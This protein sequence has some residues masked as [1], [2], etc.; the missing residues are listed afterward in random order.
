MMN[1]L[2]KIIIIVIILILI[3]FFIKEYISH[4]VILPFNYDL[5]VK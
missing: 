4:K 3:T 2:F 1:K 5:I